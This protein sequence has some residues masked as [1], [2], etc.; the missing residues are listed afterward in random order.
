MKRNR[1]VSRKTLQRYASALASR[2][3][4]DLLAEYDAAREARRRV[5]IIMTNNFF[6]LEYAS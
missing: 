4:M 5:C 6:R 1:K 2:V 3:L